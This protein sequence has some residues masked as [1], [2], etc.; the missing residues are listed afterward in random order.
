MNKHKVLHYF[1]RVVFSYD[2]QGY[3]Q[4]ASANHL[5]SMSLKGFRLAK[6]IL[7]AKVV[8]VG[9]GAGYVNRALRVI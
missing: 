4:K 9:I 5:I 2:S 1:N 7:P 3:V 8:G 6:L